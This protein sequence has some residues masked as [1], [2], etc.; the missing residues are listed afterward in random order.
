MKKIVHLLIVLIFAISSGVVF[1]DEYNYNV[2]TEK[3]KVFDHAEKVNYLQIPDDTL[4]SMSDSELIDA[5]LSYPLSLDF[6]FYNNYQFGFEMMREHFNGLNEMMNR[7]GCALLLLDQYKEKTDMISDGRD[8]EA[9]FY[10]KIWF[11]E[12]IL[13]Q[14]EI[15]SAFTESQLQELEDVVHCRNHRDVAGRE[16]ALP[17]FYRIQRDAAKEEVSTRSLIVY[18]P[19]GTPVSVIDRSYEYDTA[20]AN[21][22]NIRQYINTNYPG[23][24]IVANAT[25]RYNCHA[26]AWPQSTSFWMNDPSAY[27]NDGSYSL[28]STYSP[29][30]VGQRVTY[31]GT[32]HSGIVISLAGN[33]VRSKWG[34]YCL[35][36]HS[37]TNCP[38]Y[39]APVVLQFYQ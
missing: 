18:T 5:V 27:W 38:Y 23:V 28:A 20:L 12:A 37:L 32:T 17:V 33:G 26:F 34:E 9:E 30:A 14:P 13:A 31:A 2:D 29:T 24:N 16:N 6:I 25:V 3:Y 4:A 15:L 1:A 11:L 10:F 22:S 8:K 7:S 19:N 36:E 39:Y 35:V 21:D